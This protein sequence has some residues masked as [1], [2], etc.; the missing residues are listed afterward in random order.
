MRAEGQDLFVKTKLR[1][2]GSAC[3]Y[4]KMLLESPPTLPDSQ[5]QGKIIFA[6][7]ALEKNALF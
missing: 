3:L 4:H 2:R 5:S 7:A 6:A 1:I